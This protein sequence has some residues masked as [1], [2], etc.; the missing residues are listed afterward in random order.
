[1]R[2]TLNYGVRLDYLNAYV[3][4]QCKPADYFS[5]EL[6]TDKLPNLPNWK[7]VD[8]RFGVA[9]DVF[10]NGRTALKSAVGRYVVSEGT[11]IANKSTPSIY[12]QTSTSRTWNDANR[13]LLP[14]CNLKNPAANGECGAIL[15][16]G[17]GTI[18]RT[19]FYD[20]RLLHGFAVRPYT[21]QANA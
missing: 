15:N 16:P 13:D 17:F 20:D 4:K 10:G 1:S 3:P 12:I 6:C 11:N 18:N 9:Y 2:F 14:D 5:P 19:L 21:W 7:D 8:P